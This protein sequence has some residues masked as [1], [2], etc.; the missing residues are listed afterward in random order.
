MRTGNMGTDADNSMF[1]YYMRFYGNPTMGGG[2][3]TSTPGYGGPAL[4]GPPPSPRDNGAWG[5]GGAWGGSSNQPP[6]TTEPPKPVGTDLRSMLQ[7]YWEQVNIPRASSKNR[8]NRP[9]EQT[10]GPASYLR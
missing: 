5:A 2:T 7:N 8:F 9:N 4:T 3:G 6:A 10:I 1:N